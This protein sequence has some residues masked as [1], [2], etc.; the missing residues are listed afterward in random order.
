[1]H[2]GDREPQPVREGAR[3]VAAIALGRGR[4][5]QAARLVDDDE[6][7]VLVD[8]AEGRERR[9]VA[10]AGRLAGLLGG[11]IERPAQVGHHHLPGA[12]EPPRHLGA[13]AVDEDAADVEDDAR[14]APREIGHAGGEDLVEAPTLIGGGDDEAEALEAFTGHGVGLRRS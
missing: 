4:G 8:H 12:Q 7:V 2:D 9:L 14:L 11:A 13:R 3:Q 1:M 5:E 6:R 10:G